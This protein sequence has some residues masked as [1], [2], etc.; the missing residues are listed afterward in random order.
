MFFGVSM[1]AQVDSEYAATVAA[2]VQ[3]LCQRCADRSEVSLG[4][5]EAV[6][7][8]DRWSFFVTT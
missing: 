8:Y 2:M 5:E 7:E 3:L 6:K 1:I 4:A